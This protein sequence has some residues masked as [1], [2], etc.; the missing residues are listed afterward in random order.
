MDYFIPVKIIILAASMKSYI[1]NI[2]YCFNIFT[3][4]LIGLF[5][6][7]FFLIKTRVSIVSNMLNSQLTTFLSIFYIDYFID[8]THHYY[9]S[10]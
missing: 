10:K 7:M 1:N 8:K 2:T 9:K 3:C 6:Y 5:S 4:C